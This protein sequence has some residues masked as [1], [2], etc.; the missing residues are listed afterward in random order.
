[1]G[2]RTVLRCLGRQEALQTHKTRLVASFTVDERV[3]PDNARNGLL[4]VQLVDIGLHENSDR[5]TKQ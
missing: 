2:K 3:N 1:M 4:E 5:I